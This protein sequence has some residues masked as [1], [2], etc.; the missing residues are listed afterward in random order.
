MTM[1]AVIVMMTDMGKGWTMGIMVGKV[2]EGELR[3]RGLAQLGENSIFIVLTSHPATLL[4]TSLAST[5]K[6]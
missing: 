5:S 6:L 2:S 3:K 4:G 1:V